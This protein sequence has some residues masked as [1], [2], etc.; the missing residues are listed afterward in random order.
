MKSLVAKP[1]QKSGLDTR[2]SNRK[3]VAKLTR[4]HQGAPS[5][6]TTHQ[7]YGDFEAHV[8]YEEEP[9]PRTYAPSEQA[10]DNS[11]RTIN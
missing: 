4:H 7:E 3:L 5:G 8:Q 10:I 9:F 6:R 1:I 2:F 11:Y